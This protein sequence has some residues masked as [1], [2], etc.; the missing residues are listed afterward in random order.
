MRME[1]SNDN[2][3]LW[4]LLN[5]LMTVLA[6]GR[7]REI[8]SSG[9]RPSQFAV[10]W[11]IKNM[12]DA[13]TSAAVGRMI[14]RKPQ[15]MTGLLRR[16]DAAGLIQ[17][18]RR[19]GKGETVVLSVTE[20]GEEAFQ[21]A[22]ESQ[23]IPDAFLTLDDKERAQLYSYLKRIRDQATKSLANKYAADFAINF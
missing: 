15:A 22:I 16:M 5:Q 2:F 11:A 17:R 9:L 18:K 13:A 3:R 23:I 10:I 14:L 4:V 20:K 8:L 21:K 7:A 12:P 19:R 6:K 1:L